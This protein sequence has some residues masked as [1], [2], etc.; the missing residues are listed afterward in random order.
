[1]STNL[2]DLLKQAGFADTGSAPEPEAALA[3]PEGP[4]F[5]SKVVLRATK[6]GRGGKTVT[7]V[8]GVLRDREQL[9]KDLRKQLGV[10]TSVEGELIVVQGD[11]R[12]RLEALLAK[13][14]AKKIVL[15]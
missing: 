11:Q 13:R 7:E 12:K 3:E 14:G 15:S 5:H 6:K 9:A 1:M 2:G 8:Q 10:G 4:L